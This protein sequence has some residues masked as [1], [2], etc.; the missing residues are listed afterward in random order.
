VPNLFFNWL[1]L[2]S[3]IHLPHGYCRNVYEFETSRHD[4]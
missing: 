2:L 4:D 1:I 3:D